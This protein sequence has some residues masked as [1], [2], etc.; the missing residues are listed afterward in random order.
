MQQKRS[1]SALE[2]G[3]ALYKSDPPPQDCGPRQFPKP[4]CTPHLPDPTKT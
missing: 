2:G 1:E 4:D 3:K